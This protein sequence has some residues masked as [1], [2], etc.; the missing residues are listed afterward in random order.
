MWPT[1]A[2]RDWRSESATQEFYAKWAAN[3][4]GKTLPMML[5]L[6]QWHTPLARHGDKLDCNLPGID[7]RIALGREIGLAMQARLETA[8]AMWPTAEVQL[9]TWPTPTAS[10]GDKAIR[11]PAG[12]RTE[13]ERGKSPDLNAQ[14]MAMW[15]TPTSL[16]P[17][18]NGN[19]EAG[20]S[21]GLVAIRGHAIAG[22][23][24]TTEKPG[25]LNPQF[26][27]WLMGFPPEW[28]ACAPTAMPSSR[29]SPR[30]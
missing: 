30:K 12:A 25:A 14:I 17:A 19:N 21:A 1:P 2:A 3:T 7:R 23:S 4:K 16:A 24:A 28:D 18:K 20:N 11:T 5:A 9:A 27:C 8:R 29:R 22:S 13:V 6:G 26:A 15:S 10:L